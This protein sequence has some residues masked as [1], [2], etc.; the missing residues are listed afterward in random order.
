[1]NVRRGP[2]PPLLE[3]ALD[4]PASGWLS[5]E[6]LDVWGD[7]LDAR[8]SS[9]Y[10]V[11]MGRELIADDDARW[12]ISVAHPR[13]LPVWG[14]L[15]AIAHRLRPG[16]VFVVGVPPRSWWINVHPNC[17]HLWEMRDANLEAQW[18]AEAQGDTP[19]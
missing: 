2:L 17:L 14:D 5:L 11:L 8:P 7:E 18:R 1:V 9:P 13:R 6:A 3:R 15:V 19:T 10:S 4:A 12:H 16:V